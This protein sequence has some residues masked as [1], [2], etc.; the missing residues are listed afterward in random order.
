MSRNFEKINSLSALLE[1]SL[2]RLRLNAS[3]GN[4]S[5][6]RGQNTWKKKV[7]L[8]KFLFKKRNRFVLTPKDNK[9]S[10]FPLSDKIY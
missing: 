9:I 5:Q 2:V 10:F 4:L 1:K 3:E 6:S 8:S 7:H